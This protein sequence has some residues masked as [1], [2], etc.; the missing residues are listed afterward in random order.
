MKAATAVRFTQDSL[1]LPR[2][3]RA[4]SVRTAVRQTASTCLACGHGRDGTRQGEAKTPTGL[5]V[6]FEKP[7][8]VLIHAKAVGEIAESASLFRAYADALHQLTGEKPTV[9]LSDEKASSERIEKFSESDSRD[10][11]VRRRRNTGV[12]QT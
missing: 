12:T 4:L 7:E 2:A 6:R 1:A 8:R 11:A 3:S 5:E 10:A 9:V